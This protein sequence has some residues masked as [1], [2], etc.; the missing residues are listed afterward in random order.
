[1]ALHCLSGWGHGHSTASLKGLNQHLK[2]VIQLQLLEDDRSVFLCYTPYV[3]GLP[4]SLAPI[5]VFPHAFLPQGLFFLLL[6]STSQIQFSIRNWM[7]EKAWH[8][9]HQSAALLRSCSPPAHTCTAPSRRAAASPHILN[10]ALKNE[11]DLWQGEAESQQDA[12]VTHPRATA[13]AATLSHSQADSI[14]FHC[15]C[16][17]VLCF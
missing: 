2:G 4:L 3:F 6:I 9:P 14:L 1:M 5:V 11:G 10:A 13:R 8:P 17:Q 7:Y 12:S 15:H 16:K